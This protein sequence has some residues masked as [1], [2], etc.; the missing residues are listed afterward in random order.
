MQEG[1]VAKLSRVTASDKEPLKFDWDFFSVFFCYLPSFILLCMSY[2]LSS[3]GV[4]SRDL[5]R[6]PLD[7]G[8]SVTTV[9]AYSVIIDVK[10]RLG[11]YVMCEIGVAE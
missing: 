6:F 2:L 9:P 10:V 5:N 8:F 3:Y 4:G 1:Y 11:R 7:C